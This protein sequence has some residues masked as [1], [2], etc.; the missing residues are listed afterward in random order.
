MAS[1][2]VDKP[3]LDVFRMFGMMQGKRIAVNRRNAITP[4]QVITSGVHGSKPDINALASKSDHAIFTMVWNYHD[5]HLPGP[6]AP[7][8][9]E[10]KNVD[11]NKMLLQQYRIDEHH[12]NSYTKWREMGAPQQVTPQQYKEIE[13]AGHLESFGSPKWIHLSDEKTT[14]S[15]ML[16]R[17]GVSL[18]KLSW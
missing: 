13:Q 16:P 7:V 2:G 18:F 6:D 10:L 11:E 5:D 8:N 17:H 12:S 14:I 15:L 1:N 3:V 9:I 4:Q